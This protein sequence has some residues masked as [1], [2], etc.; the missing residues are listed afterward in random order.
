MGHVGKT[1]RFHL[2]SQFQWVNLSFLLQYIYI[3]DSMFEIDPSSC[4]I[5]YVIE[6][7]IY[8]SEIGT[9][10]LHT[11]IKTI[12]IAYQ[13][14][15]QLTMEYFCHYFFKT[16]QL[17]IYINYL[18]SVKPSFIITNVLFLLYI[19]F[20]PVNRHRQERLLARWG[21]GKREN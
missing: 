10:P 5:L 18:V 20:W 4:P 17:R 8:F 1:N 7:C 11:G 3:V 9:H 21:P 15:S 2:K 14:M 19:D 16:I 6:S 12:K 13:F